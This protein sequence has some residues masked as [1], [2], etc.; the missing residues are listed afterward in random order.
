MLFGEQRLIC[1]QSKTRSS[2]PDKEEF[3]QTP[4][5]SQFCSVCVFWGDFLSIS[6]AL[7]CLHQ[8]GQNHLCSKEEEP[9]SHKQW[10]HGKGINPLQITRE[11]VMESCQEAGLRYQKG[12]YPGKGVVQKA[13]EVPWQP[14]HSEGEGGRKEM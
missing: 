7:S 2:V 13:Q 8:R 5:F 14:D 3:I 12:S 11:G 1:A 10:E 4:L 9:S 6:L